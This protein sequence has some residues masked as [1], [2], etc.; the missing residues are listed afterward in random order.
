MNLFYI[1]LAMFILSFIAMAVG[2]IFSNKKISGSCGGLSKVFLN[3]DTE[4]DGNCGVCG[5]SVEERVKKGC[6][7]KLD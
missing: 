3:G 7:K 2:V 1:I 6:L 4:D 5:A